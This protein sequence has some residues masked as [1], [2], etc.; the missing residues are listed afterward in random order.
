MVLI[1]QEEFL[2]FISYKRRGRCN[3]DGRKEVWDKGVGRIFF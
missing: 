3:D 2:P 1:R